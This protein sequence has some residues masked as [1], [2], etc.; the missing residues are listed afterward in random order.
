MQNNPSRW[1][2]LVTLI[3]G[4]VLW[5]ALTVGAVLLTS[6][7]TGL[8]PE[9]STRGLPLALYGLLKSILA[10]ISLLLSARIAAMRAVDLGLTSQNWRSDA[11]IGMAAGTAW[12]LLELF[13]LIPLTGGGARSDVIASLGLTEGTWI[14]VLGVI[15]AGWLAGGLSEELFFRGYLIPSV[16]NLLGGG[17]WAATLAALI[18]VFWF[19]LGHAYQGWAGVVDVVISGLLYT[20]LYLWRGRL[21]A[22]I[23]AHGWFDM[24]IIVGV[25]VMYGAG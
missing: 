5:Y 23:V 12:A 2:W 17:K 13:V 21:T 18:S 7:L 6:M 9:E 22:S 10:L 15:I 4:A 8:P 16:R 3:V 11:L 1:R 14:G 24:V 20:A 19:A 25:F